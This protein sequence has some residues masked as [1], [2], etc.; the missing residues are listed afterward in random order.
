M[1]EDFGFDF[2][3]FRY[4][5]AKITVN[6]ENFN[7]V[8]VEGDATKWNELDYDEQHEIKVEQFD[9]KFESMFE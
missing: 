2:F 1:R 9:I 4:G 5:K 6:A 8:K 3:S 7:V